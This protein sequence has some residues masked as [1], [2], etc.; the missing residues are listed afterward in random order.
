LVAA[1][2]ARAAFH[3]RLFRFRWLRRARWADCW[4]S[5]QS[6]AAVITVVSSEAKARIPRA[7]GADHTIIISGEGFAEAARRLN[8]MGVQYSL[9]V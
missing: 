9:L 6:G 4:C 3:H 7:D 8:R 5:S 2:V 1:N